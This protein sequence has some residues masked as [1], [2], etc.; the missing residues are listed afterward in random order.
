MDIIK[1]AKVIN[2][3]YS[4]HKASIKD[5][6]DI[7]TL[8]VNGPKAV[9]LT[10][11]IANSL[12]K[13]TSLLPPPF[14]TLLM[15]GTKVVGRVAMS[16]LAI[17][18]AKRILDQ[19][20]EVIQT[21]LTEC[22]RIQKSAQSEEL[23][24]VLDKFE[25]D[26]NTFQ[27]NFDG[28]MDKVRG[29]ALNNLLFPPNLADSFKEL[30]A[31]I[32]IWK[33]TI[34]HEL[35]I[36]THETVVDIKFDTKNIVTT[37]TDVKDNQEKAERRAL[38]DSVSEKLKE[39]NPRSMQKRLEFARAVY[40]EN[41]L[42]Q[43][44]EELKLWYRNYSHGYLLKADEGTGKTVFASKIGDMLE[45]EVDA[46]LVAYFLP[47]KNQELPTPSQN[48]T[49][50]IRKTTERD[51]TYKPLNV[52][53]SW[54]L[55]LSKNIEF[56]RILNTQSILDAKNGEDH[57]DVH[58]FFQ[59]LI[60]DP[61][62]KIGMNAI[63]VLDAIDDLLKSS[64]SEMA[65]L[66]DCLET[67]T[68]PNVRF[69][70]TGSLSYEDKW[71]T[72]KQS[73]FY[74]LQLRE[75][76][77]TAVKRICR[78]G[79]ISETDVEKIGQELRT[80][81]PMK[82][83]VRARNFAMKLIELLN[84]TVEKGNESNNA[85]SSRAPTGIDGIDDLVRAKVE[86]GILFTNHYLDEVNSLMKEPIW[87]CLIEFSRNYWTL[88][89]Y[90]HHCPFDI[91]VMQQYL[92]TEGFVITVEELLTMIDSRKY[93]F[94]NEVVSTTSRIIQEKQLDV[95]LPGVQ[96]NQN[97]FYMM[98]NDREADNN[99]WITSIVSP[100]IVRA[101]ETLKS[102]LS[103]PLYSQNPDDI[104]ITSLMKYF[105][106][107]LHNMLVINDVYELRYSNAAIKAIRSFFCPESV[108][109]GD[110][111]YV[112]LWLELLSMNGIKVTRQMCLKMKYGIKEKNEKNLEV[113]EDLKALDDFFTELS[114][115]VLEFG[116]MLL[117]AP[118][119]VFKSML[120]SLP[121]STLISRRYKQ[122]YLDH[123]YI[124]LYTD[125]KD[126]SI[127][128][129][130]YETDTD[131]IYGRFGYGK[132]NS[133][134]ICTKRGIEFYSLDNST[135]EIGKFKLPG[136]YNIG[137]YSSDNYSF[138]AA[139]NS[140]SHH[141]LAFMK[142]DIIQFQ[143]E[144]PGP[145]HILV[146][147]RSLKPTDEKV[148]VV[149]T[150]SNRMY[151]WEEGNDSPVASF[152]CD[153]R[154]TAAKMDVNAVSVMIGLENGTVIQWCKRTGKAMPIYECGC[155]VT[156]LMVGTQEWE[157]IIITS[158]GVITL[159]NMELQFALT[160]F[161]E[162][163]RPILEC[164]FDEVT[165]VLISV[166]DDFVVKM[167]D[168]KTFS[169]TS[170]STRYIPITHPA[171]INIK[172]E[173][174]LLLCTFPDESLPVLC[175][176]DAV[177][178]ETQ[179]SVN[180]ESYV[181]RT[182]NIDM[183]SKFEDSMM[184][185]VS[186]DASIIV[187]VV[188][189]YLEIY[190]SEGK[191]QHRSAEKLENIF[192][193]LVSDDGQTI[194]TYYKDSTI[195]HLWNTKCEKIGDFNNHI[196]NISSGFVSNDGK[197]I[198]TASIGGNL[199]V[200]NKNFEELQRIEIGRHIEAVTINDDQNLI[201][202]S[203]D[204]GDDQSEVR[205]VD[206]SGNT[207]YRF[208]VKYDCNGLRFNEDSTKLLISNGTPNHR[209]LVYDFIN[210]IETEELQH[211][212]VQ[213]S[214]MRYVDSQGLYDFNFEGT[215]TEPLCYFK[216]NVG[217][218]GIMHSDLDEDRRIFH[219]FGN[220]IVKFS[221]PAKTVEFEPFEIRTVD[222]RVEKPHVYWARCGQEGSKL[223]VS[224]VTVSSDD[225]EVAHGDL[226]ALEEI[227]SNRCP[228][229]LFSDMDYYSFIYDVEDIE[230]ADHDIELEA[231]DE[232][233]ELTRRNTNR[234]RKATIARGL[235]LKKAVS[236]EPESFNVQE[237]P[238]VPSMD[239]HIPA[240]SVTTI[241]PAA[242]SEPTLELKPKSTPQNWTEFDV[243]TEK[244]VSCWL[245]C[246]VVNQITNV[247]RYSQSQPSEKK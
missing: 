20:P 190:D 135:S 213:G 218:R 123:D 95:P 83:F 128:I 172:A 180:T 132:D 102:G 120:I 168:M 199:I 12:E 235:V 179:A 245:P 153:S 32:Q 204:M 111:P 234:M 150:S 247:H 79:K 126:W 4:K 62:E 122:E 3:H 101:V 121:T 158:D 242:I 141:T 46:P 81:R 61:C 97:T 237:L 149:T 236:F 14:G 48:L 138:T 42:L 215:Q 47:Q 73:I 133:V 145:I 244:K 80:Y 93:L 19:V 144:H 195:A 223:N 52:I 60:V 225:F 147:D 210:D 176:L 44:T 24:A 55:Q 214:A 194:V 131:G 65:K 165:N 22:H 185:G 18:T 240:E 116:E 230:M 59:D 72:G 87:K 29:P 167:W 197:T 227:Y 175:D 43:K 156:K 10:L 82:S 127:E 27:Q 107:Q 161:T 15:I 63:L 183:N 118:S 8:I 238:P 109:Q 196:S 129:C 209:A 224:Q 134:A 78:D 23:K 50:K 200:W 173:E 2:S 232:N 117:E 208:F 154:I 226:H 69:V 178:Y 16:Y 170:L 160:Q 84:N 100:W 205:I 171:Q 49:N 30:K 106:S 187:T 53:S 220:E 1:H 217:M 212:F 231:F 28:A 41:T 229:L 233:G 191:L 40:A 177:G 139:I 142:Y 25:K 130:R 37:V 241:A 125:R 36:E 186:K 151:L 157:L 68:S 71:F 5:V 159:Y 105:G 211:C 89:V 228:D 189:G 57:E 110:P 26:L 119:E 162:H 99:D 67:L 77:I 174:R 92:V 86:E 85:D 34:D 169:E 184:V 7:G 113:Q 155:S 90:G 112:L 216:N 103:K 94:D 137:A 182:T 192:N 143:I 163:E 201:A 21:A 188:D 75:D 114:K 243:S 152:K 98:Y 33:S 222:R 148:F 45:S 124:Q 202:L 198:M 146:D 17:E 31:N 207:K 108:E 164:A 64:N 56:A 166:S 140:N 219:Y 91:N 136:M 221:I 51:V 239:K 76:Y 35:N 54:A 88:G 39:F 115:I 203:I 181:L 104:H 38:R 74:P 9:E 70:I 193:I 246:I 96:L 206:T 13:F 66:I 58:L 11:A 6:A